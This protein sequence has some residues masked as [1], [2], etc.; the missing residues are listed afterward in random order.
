MPNHQLPRLCDPLDHPGETQ[1]PLQVLHLGLFALQPLLLLLWHPNLKVLH[2]LQ[3][4]QPPLVLLPLLQTRFQLVNLRRQK[5]GDA[6]FEEFVEVEALSNEKVDAGGLAE[7]PAIWS[8][9]SEW[10]GEN[11]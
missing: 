3:L 10:P 9:S 7:E 11:S 2:R 6:L 4:A 1:A 8:T 5:V